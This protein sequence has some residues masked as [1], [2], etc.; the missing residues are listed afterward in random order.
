[1]L[2]TLVGYLTAAAEDP[3]S[4]YKV[5]QHSVRLLM[6]IGDLLIGWRLLVGATVA[7]EALDGSPSPGDRPFYEGKIAAASFF[8]KTVLPKLSARRAIVDSA[9][10]ELMELAEAAF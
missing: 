3:Q 1:M 10:N 6:S 5:G 2:G 8:A 4:V 7:Q 9:D